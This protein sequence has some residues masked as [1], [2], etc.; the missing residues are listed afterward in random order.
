[1]RAPWGYGDSG[2][3]VR[4]A[5]C[6]GVT[7]PSPSLN[8]TN[9]AISDHMTANV[10]ACPATTSYAK[11]YDFFGVAG[12]SFN[13]SKAGNYTVSANYRGWVWLNLS[14]APNRSRAG[15]VFA[16]Y[17]VN[18]SIYIWSDRAN[19]YAAYDIVTITA[20]TIHWGT[21]SV[22]VR[23]EGGNVSGYLVHGEYSMVTAIT[24]SIGVEANA[25]AAVSASA[26]ASVASSA[27]AELVSERIT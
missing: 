24:P 22:R 23:L 4:H 25:S 10:S 20:R 26:T 15:Q 1:M 13:V 8:L 16:Y 5:G 9:G 3:G 17:E 18:V 11:V 21:A 12:N 19:R 6:F 7:G 27:N 14:V 2:Y